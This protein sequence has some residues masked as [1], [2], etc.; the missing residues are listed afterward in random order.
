MTGAPPEPLAV[1]LESPADEAARECADI[2][3]GGCAPS[4][5]A[6]ERLARRTLRR[7]PG[8]VLVV[9]RGPEGSCLARTRAGV[10][11]TAVSPTPSHRPGDAELLGLACALYVQLLASARRSVG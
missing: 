2:L 7:Y 10:A 3:Y 9:L 11:W 5:V 4:R 1:R 6:A 8:C